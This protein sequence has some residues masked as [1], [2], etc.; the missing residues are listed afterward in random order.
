MMEADIKSAT[1]MSA[2]FWA[3][4]FGCCFGK[5]FANAFVGDLKL[6]SFTKEAW[7]NGFGLIAVT[8][9]EEL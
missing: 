7:R 3:I 2:V 4:F 5:N 1:L 8:P 9:K 6:V